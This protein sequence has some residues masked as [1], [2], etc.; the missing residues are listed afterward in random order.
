VTALFLEQLLREIIE[1]LEQHFG[2]FLDVVY[3]GDSRVTIQFKYAS[4]DR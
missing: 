4:P 2:S 3:G 1:L